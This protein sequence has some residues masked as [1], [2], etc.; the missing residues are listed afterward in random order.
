LAA[1]AELLAHHRLILD[2]LTAAGVPVWDLYQ[3]GRWVPHCTISMRVPNPSMATAIRRC[4]E[5]LPAPAAVTDHANGISR[6]R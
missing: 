5:V 3:P 4:L 1:L 6:P 2:R